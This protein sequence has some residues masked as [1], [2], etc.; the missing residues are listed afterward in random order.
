MV[1]V[2]KSFSCRPIVTQVGDVHPCSDD[3]SLCSCVG[4]EK[5]LYEN[6][7]TNSLFSG[8]VLRKEVLSSGEDQQQA[9]VVEVGGRG[10][11]SGEAKFWVEQGDKIG[12]GFLLQ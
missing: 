3:L 4:G 6:P 7:R 8:R 10:H 2:S 9:V 12:H 5:R 11:Y 1:T